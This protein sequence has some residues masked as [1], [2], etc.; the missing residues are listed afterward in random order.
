MSVAL[1]KPV[2]EYSTGFKI[3]YSIYNAAIKNST[4]K[5]EYLKSNGL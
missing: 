5:R 2:E 3:I 4:I 1:K